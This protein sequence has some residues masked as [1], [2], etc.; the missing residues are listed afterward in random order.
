MIELHDTE[1]ISSIRYMKSSQ[2]IHCPRCGSQYFRQTW[3]EEHVEN[4][5]ISHASVNCQDCNWTALMD[6]W[7]VYEAV[8][9]IEAE[10]ANRSR[11]L[12]KV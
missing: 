5:F 1:H 10:N 2:Q 8:C 11:S 6:M 4:N 7:R 3:H 12:P 9:S